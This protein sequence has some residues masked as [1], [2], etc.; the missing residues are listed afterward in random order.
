MAVASAAFHNLIDQY[1]R[2]IFRNFYRRDPFISLVPRKEFDTGQGLTPLVVSHTGELPTAYLDITP[3]TADDMA[4]LNI[5]DGPGSSGDVVATRVQTGQDQ[6]N[7]TLKVDAWKSD[8]INMSDMTF[9]EDP[10][11]TVANVY[12]S[13]G[14]FA[15]VKTSDWH[16]IHNI[17]MLDNKTVVTAAGVL[18]STTDTNFNHHGITL[19]LEGTLNAAGTDATHFDVSTTAGASAVDDAYNSPG[20]GA[21]ICIVFGTGVFPI[22]QA[23]QAIT[24][25]VGATMIGEVGSWPFGTP[26]GT[27]LFRILN[28]N[29]PADTLDWT[30]TMP[31]IFDEVE[32]IGGPNFAIGFAD[33]MA[34]YSLTLG[35]EAKRKLF[36][37][38]LQVD[39]RYDMPHE[40]FTARGIS[41]A[42][43]GF[44][45]NTDSFPIRYD[46]CYVPIY[47]TINAAATLG[48]KFT[49]NPDYRPVS[50]GGKALYESGTV[51]TRE[52]YEAR[53]R[54]VDQTSLDRAS[55]LP[56][57]Y[58][59]EV[60][61]INNGT[62]EGANDLQNKG[63]FRADWQ[64]GAK[65]VRPE[66][67]WA[68]LYKIPSEV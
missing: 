19:H 59:S 55:F 53:P 27:S 58:M 62:F 49:L 17:G 26:D 3:G 65:P 33:G 29:V 50:L 61:W 39:I 4:N 56:T 30:E 13:L 60:R 10:K 7:Y 6:R 64:L 35:P 63:F 16:R 1:D 15:I 34:V 12:D 43:N 40:N 23:P 24:D 67:G 20:N 5:T 38:D 52:V 45:P 11:G 32:R 66:L 25:Y 41:K 21:G 42:I 48:R 44:I 18:T 28:T 31:F 68:I 2:Y 47:P 57:N 9:R 22:G 36:K 14:E 37:A 46:Q 8:V 51:L 54:P